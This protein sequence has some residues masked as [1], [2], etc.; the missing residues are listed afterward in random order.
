[1]PSAARSGASAE[2]LPGAAD[3]NLPALYQDVLLKRANVEAAARALTTPETRELAYELAA[4]VCDA[5]GAQS[6]PERA[7]LASL[8][9]ALGMSG[10][11]A[12]AI[13]ATA[14]ALATAP[15][16]AASSFEPPG[17]NPA[18]GRGRARR[19]RR[20]CRRPRWTR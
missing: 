7:F 11:T 18:A 10:A 15:L 9:A 8:R 5:D 19:S 6:G 2:S 20:R 16:A 13:D 3:L 14:E 4:G 1:M 17:G 12:Q